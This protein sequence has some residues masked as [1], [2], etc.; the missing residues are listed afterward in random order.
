MSTCVACCIA[1]ELNEDNGQRVRCLPGE[2]S[3]VGFHDC[4]RR[5]S[6]PAAPLRV[7]REP[8]YYLDDVHSVKLM[9]LNADML[10]SRQPRACQF[11]CHEVN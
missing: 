10:S 9:G 1:R 11:S 6:P 5:S 4:D 2:K 8:L 7:S 3:G